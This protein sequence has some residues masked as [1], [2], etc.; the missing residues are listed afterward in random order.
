MHL[1]LPEELERYISAVVEN[2]EFTSREEL[3][4]DALRLHRDRAAKLNTLRNELQLAMDELDRGEGITINNDEEHREYWAAMRRQ[5][6]EER[7][8][9]VN[10]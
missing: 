3:L 7:E 4:A 2:G 8:A 1:E 10:P 5:V 6:L 9:S